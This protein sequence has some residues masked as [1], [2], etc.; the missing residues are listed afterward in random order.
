MT[1]Y[2]GYQSPFSWRYGSPEMRRIWSLEATR[3]LWRQIWVILAEAQVPFGL[4]SDKQAAELRK[5]QYRLDLQQSL[6]LER[7]LQH[8][9]MAELRV[10]GSQCPEAAGVLHLGATSMDIKDNALVMQQRTALDLILLRLKGLLGTL[11][12]LI[13]E[14]AERPVMGFT[15]LQPAEPSTLG[16]RLAQTAQDLLAGYRELVD[17]RRDIKGKGFSGAVGTSASFSELLGE[18]NLIP[19]QE[20]LSRRLE[21]E[22]HPAVT[23]TYPRLQD[24]RLLTRLAGLGGAIY[25]FA[26]DLRI[27]QSPG[28]GELAEP[29][30]KDQVGSSAMPF[31][32]NPIR[33]EKINSLGRYLAQ[34]PRIAW[35]NAAHNLLERTLDDSANRRIILP[36]GFL[37]LDEMLISLGQILADLQIRPVAVQANLAD[38]GPFAATEKLL[39][40]LSKAGADRQ[41]MHETIRA[42]ALEAWE[43]VRQGRSNPLMDLVAGSPQLQDYLEA[44]EIRT[45]LAG[46][47][48]LGD[49]VQRALQ[50]ADQIRSTIA[51]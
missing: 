22:F 18:E 21:L 31:K 2:A 42:L 10:F 32:Q 28:F 5:S 39:M 17:F 40:A 3:L 16:Y 6:E 23:Q 9:L 38:Y 51:D 36:E 13:T 12:E 11:A 1:E 47:A 4:V 48:Y 34:L 15:H 35:D 33:S 20:D 25:K 24:Y 26:F 27:L 44:G 19:F 45:I 8:D 37:C 50:V 43:E 7:R 49:A 41:S 29:F 14:Q 46:E 30:G